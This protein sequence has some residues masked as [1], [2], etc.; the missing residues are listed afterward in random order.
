VC[1][2]SCIA[3]CQVFVT[4]IWSEQ[5]HIFQHLSNCLQTLIDLLVSANLVSKDIFLGI[6]VV[7]KPFNLA[8]RV[9]I[10]SVSK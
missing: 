3:V 10:F 6:V 8:L 4:F 2:A 5:K 9:V 1:C 7:C